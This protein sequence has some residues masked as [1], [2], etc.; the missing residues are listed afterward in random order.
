MPDRDTMFECL[1]S[2]SK[3]MCNVQLLV[4]I[5]A[6]FTLNILIMFL[7]NLNFIEEES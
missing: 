1:D 2:L 4:H 7:A 6:F 5:F 3:V